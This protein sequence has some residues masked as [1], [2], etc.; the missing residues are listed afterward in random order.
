MGTD[1]IDQ[2]AKAA[3]VPVARDRKTMKF[4]TFERPGR[5]LKSGCGASAEVPHL[6]HARARSMSPV[7]RV[8]HSAVRG[9]R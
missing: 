2:I 7:G 8:S 3:L 4:P 1:T 9:N 6:A 5:V